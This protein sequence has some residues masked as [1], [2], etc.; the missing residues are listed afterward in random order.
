MTRTWAELEARSAPFPR[1]ARFR[2]TLVLAWPDGHDEV[3]EGRIEGQCVWPMRGTQ[4]HGYDPMFQ[5]NGH[6]ADPRSDGPLGEEPD[7]PPRRRLRQDGGGLP[8][9]R[10]IPRTGVRAD[11]A[12][13]STGRSAPRNAPTATSTA[14]SAARWTRTAGAGRWSRTYGRWRRRCRAAGCDSVFFG[15]GTPSL[16]PPETVAAV[17]DA[18]RGGW[19]LAPGAE[20]TL[21]ANPTSV[22]AGRFRGYRDAGVNRL[23]LGVQALNDAD[24]RALGRLH[25]VAEAVRAFETA[26]AI[27]P[28]VSF[29]LIYARQHQDAAAW[30]AELARAVA[31]AVDHLSLYQLTIEPGTRFGELAARGRLR[32]LP[33]AEPRRRPLPRHARALRARRPAQL[34]G[35]QPRPAGRRR[36]AQPRLLALRRLRRHRAGRARPPDPRRA[37]GHDRAPPPGGLAGG[38]RARRLRRRRADARRAGRPGSRDA[39]DGASPRRRRRPGPLHA[40]SPERRSIRALWP[41]SPNSAWS[42]QPQTVSGQR[43]R[44]APCSMPS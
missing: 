44:G 42:R 3:F 7:Q 20:I 16:M 26:R 39:D 30:R 35:F 43:P 2:C 12:S 25:D 1:T 27:F 10:P 18:V 4:G 36:P 19:T 8:W 32:G 22:E 17:I 40:R 6:D 33:D 23:S 9:L 13:T 38:G 37:L 5:P 34:R 15:G 28:R 21:E 41:S 31:M 14:T 24:L 11:S 29:D